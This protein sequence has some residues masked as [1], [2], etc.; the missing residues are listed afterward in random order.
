MYNLFKEYTLGNFRLAR[1]YSK[2]NEYNKFP[3]VLY[4]NYKVLI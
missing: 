3:K 4:D 1:V 2:Y